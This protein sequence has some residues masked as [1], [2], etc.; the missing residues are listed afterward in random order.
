MMQLEAFKPFFLMQINQEGEI[1][2]RTF[3]TMTVLSNPHKK[4]SHLPVRQ[5]FISS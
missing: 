1:K 3:V 5:H 4:Q 2:T